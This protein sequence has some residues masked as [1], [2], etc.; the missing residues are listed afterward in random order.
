M[1]KFYQLRRS[2]PDSF[3]SVRI[4]RKAAGTADHLEVYKRPCHEDY[5]SLFKITAY[6]AGLLPDLLPN[7]FGW[8]IVSPRFCEL[9]ESFQGGG[10][11]VLTRADS[12]TSE[13]KLPE[14]AGYRLV[15]TRLVLDCLD[16]SSS[17]LEWFDDSKKVLKAYQKLTLIGNSIPL[18]ACF[19]GV[20]RA[21]F[22][23]ILR[24]DLWGHLVKARLTGVR[25]VECDVS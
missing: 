4:D 3:A 23:H 14:L 13:L 1:N 17:W 7:N 11:P 5:L 6:N 12:M 9:L 25:F 8:S 24:E 19:F 21:P 18:S 10:K 16:L 22:M 2:W 20:V 15:S